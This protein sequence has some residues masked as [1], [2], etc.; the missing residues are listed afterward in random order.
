MKGKLGRPRLR[1]LLVAVL[2]ATSLGAIVGVAHAQRHYHTYNSIAHGVV[3][4]SDTR[5]NN[6]HARVDS[7]FG[8]TN[9]CLLGDEGTFPWYHDSYHTTV[10]TDRC[11]DY[12]RDHYRGYWNECRSMAAVAHSSR[13]GAHTHLAHNYYAA[14]CR[15]YNA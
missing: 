9:Y 12:N 15:L 14:P 11:N 1:L 3:H 2:G 5:D 8:G 7:P 6:F 10:G 13:L 4:G